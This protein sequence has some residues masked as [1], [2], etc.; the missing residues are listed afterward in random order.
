MVADATAA[1][2]QGPEFP[3]R[4]CH[5]TNLLKSA[6]GAASFPPADRV[7]PPRAGFATRMR[8]ARIDHQNAFA[9]ILQCHGELSAW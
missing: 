8:C 1:F 4:S 9:D 3:L 2:R 6:P 5:F 7:I